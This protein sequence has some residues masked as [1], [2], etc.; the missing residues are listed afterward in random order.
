[1]STRHADI[2]RPWAQIEVHPPGA[3]RETGSAL[4]RFD[5]ADAWRLLEPEAQAAI[6][7][8]ALELAV[9]R[10][11]MDLSRDMLEERLFEAAENEAASHL[12]ERAIEH[13][14]DVG[15]LPRD[16]VPGV[17]S[18]LG[19]ICRQCGCTEHDACWTPPW[20]EG[21]SWAGPD[22]CSACA[23]DAPASLRAS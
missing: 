20:G 13:L 7:A 23:A 14:T 16:Q 8:A 9:A 10:S 4:S 17:P 2:A 11:G 3:P 12:E 5:G 6:G 1:M 22:L 19:P 21:C 18:L 15:A